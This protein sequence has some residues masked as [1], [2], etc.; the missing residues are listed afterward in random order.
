MPKLQHKPQLMFPQPAGLP[1]QHG[2][3]RSLIGGASLN[4]GMPPP[5]SLYTKWWKKKLME[6]NGK[7]RMKPPPT[8]IDILGSIILLTSIES[9]TVKPTFDAPKNSYFTNTHRETTSK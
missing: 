3:C 5:P 9:K 8:M 1:R 2:S 6:N 4:R 7:R